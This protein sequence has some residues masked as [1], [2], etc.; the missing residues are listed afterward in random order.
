MSRRQDNSCSAD[1]FRSRARRSLAPG[2]TCRFLEHALDSAC[3]DGSFEKD[4]AGLCDASRTYSSQS[5]IKVQRGVLIDVRGY[6]WTTRT[7]RLAIVL[8]GSENG[9]TCHAMPCNFG[10][11]SLLHYCNDIQTSEPQSPHQACLRPPKHQQGFA[12]HPP[13]M[14]RMDQCSGTFV[15]VGVGARGDEFRIDF[16]TSFSASALQSRLHHM[17]IFQLIWRNLRHSNSMD[18]S[19]SRLHSGV[20]TRLPIWT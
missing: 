5:P 1:I 4:F 18:L 7:I 15:S 12:T 17:W 2:S 3:I 11:D 19:L 10:N 20:C 6:A 14:E 13:A 8:L 9:L 16:H